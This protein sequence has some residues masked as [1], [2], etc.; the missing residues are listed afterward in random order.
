MQDRKEGADNF[1]KIKTIYRHVINQK[2]ILMS[3]RTN[4]Q[5]E[6]APLMICRL[7]RNDMSIDMI[8]L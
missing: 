1:I 7:L 5:K 4:L 3:D 6:C 8:I 2:I